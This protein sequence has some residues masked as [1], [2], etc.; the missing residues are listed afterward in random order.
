VSPTSPPDQDLLP[1]P[2]LTVVTGAGGW[3]GRAFLHALG[4]GDQA[5]AELGPVAR[6]GPVRAL[7]QSP[8]DVEGVLE[9]LPSAEVHVGDVADEGV[10]AR[11][12]ADAADASVVHAA[13]VIHA[14]KV[15]EFERVNTG[16][17]RAVL[18]AARGA[19]ARRLVYM[20][21]NSPFGV[22]ATAT[23][24]FRH[25]EPFDPY[26]GY[27]HSKMKAEQLVRQAH[28]DDGLET[29]IVRPPWFYGPFQPLRQTTFF[30]MVRTGRFPLLGS[31][32]QR[33]SMVYVDNLVQ[34][35]ARAERVRRAAGDAFWVADARAYPMLEIVQTVKQALREEG[36][37]VADRQVRLPAF[38][39]RVAERIDGVL[40]SRGIY[41]QEFHVLG[42]MDKTIACDIS[43]TT[44]VLG[45]QPAVELL[46]GMRRSIR[47]CREQ[48]VEI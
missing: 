30:R 16:G 6:A 26:M 13:G 47:W 36:Y 2:P 31:G 38:A 21:S 42:E 27:G 4:Q 15:T 44:Q 33:R 32:R 28:E 35:V 18:E 17:T 41:H 29:V 37:E 23:D 22:N 20:S 12:F 14:A 9:V 48:G 8:G 46:E 43:T 11:L 40:Q 3:F 25:D 39:G 24:V 1:V 10:L 34:G 5:S 19:G 7:V 45:Y